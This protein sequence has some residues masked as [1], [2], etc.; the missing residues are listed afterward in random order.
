VGKGVGSYRP[1]YD[2]DAP[3]SRQTFNRI[4]YALVEYV[5]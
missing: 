1:R 4:T 5:E 2:A 3:M